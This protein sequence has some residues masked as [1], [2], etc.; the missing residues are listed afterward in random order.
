[1]ADLPD[2]YT[3][4]QISEAE[5]AKF[6]GG[7]DDNKSDTPVSRDIYY[8]TDSKILRVCVVDGTWININALYLLLAGGTMTGAIAM[9]GN[10][11]TGLGAPAAAGDALRYGQ[12]E[13]RNAEIAAGAAIAYAKLALTGAIKAADIEAAAGIPLTKLEDEVCSDTELANAIAGLKM[14]YSE[15]DDLSD[16]TETSLDNQTVGATAYHTFLNIAAGGC[17]FLGGLLAV[18]AGGR[19]QTTARITVDGGAEQTIVF[20]RGGEGAADSPAIAELPP[21][22]CHTSLLIQTYNAGG[23]GYEYGGKSWHRAL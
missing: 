2:Y 11:V 3:Q 9:G 13:I 8:A 6:K 7:L 15:A 14:F 4:A 16:L 10:K 21:I 20:V 1:M 5:A 12:A 23:S 18:E 22:L 17:R 19:I